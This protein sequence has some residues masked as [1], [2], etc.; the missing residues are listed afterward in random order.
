MIVRWVWRNCDCRGEGAVRVVNSQVDKAGVSPGLLPPAAA[1]ARIDA[2]W[3]EATKEDAE[4]QV[5]PFLPPEAVI[6]SRTLAEEFRELADTMGVPARAF[7]FLVAKDLSS[8]DPRPVHFPVHQMWNA[9]SPFEPIPEKKIT[10]L[11][12]LRRLMRPWWMFWV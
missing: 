6:E 12:D 9:Y 8:I 3:V 11:K 1:T 7:C 10:G 5:F 2:Y 4:G